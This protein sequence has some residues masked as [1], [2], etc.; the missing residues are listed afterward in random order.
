[1]GAHVRIR[2]CYSKGA[3]RASADS[4]NSLPRTN[5]SYA[6]KCRGEAVDRAV[7]PACVLRM[8]HE[9]RRGDDEHALATNS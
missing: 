7:F 9:E 2:L 1:M 6:P 3:L 5:N 8:S 4:L